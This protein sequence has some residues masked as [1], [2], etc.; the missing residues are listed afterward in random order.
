MESRKLVLP[1]FTDMRESFRGETMMSRSEA[2]GFL[3]NHR[4]IG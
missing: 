2:T 3:E 4:D 1:C